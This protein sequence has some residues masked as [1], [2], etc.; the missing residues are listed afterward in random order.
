MGEPGAGKSALL[1]NWAARTARSR[2]DGVL[3]HFVGSTAASEDWIVPGQ[4]NLKIITPQKKLNIMRLSPSA[5]VSQVEPP[6][7]VAYSTMPSAPRTAPEKPTS[8]TRFRDLRSAGASS[9]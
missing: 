5:K 2:P 9:A 6:S 3:P 1:A 4:R 7:S 8:N